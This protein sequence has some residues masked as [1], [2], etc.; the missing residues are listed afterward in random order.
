MPDPGC[1]LTLVVL[2]IGSAI[3]PVLKRQSGSKYISM[4]Q[5]IFLVLLA[6]AGSSDAQVASSKKTEVL[7]PGIFHFT[8]SGLDVAKFDNADILL[9][10]RQQE[11]RDLV[12]NLKKIKPDK[13]F[14]EVPATSQKKYDSLFSAYSNNHD[15]GYQSSKIKMSLDQGA[16]H[17]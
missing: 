13:I 12:A 6:V 15:A 9:E 14:I 10:K 17:I 5:F 7:L 3:L 2:I 4:K 8:T 11:V 1:Q 16:E